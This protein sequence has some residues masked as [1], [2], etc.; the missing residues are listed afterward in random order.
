MGKGPVEPGPAAFASGTA[1]RSP[2]EVTE[3]LRNAGLEESEIV[4]FG[5][6]DAKRLGPASAGRVS[7]L[8]EHFSPDELKALGNFLFR[9]DIVINDKFVQ[10]LL[11][12]VERGHLVEK[13]SSLEVAA[14]YTSETATIVDVEGGLS[15]KISS[16]KRS[17]AAKVKAPSAPKVKEPWE[18]AEEQ[19]GPAL[20]KLYGK[21]WRY[22]ERVP[23][24]GVQPGETL[25]STIPEYYHP[26][27]NPPLHLKRNDYA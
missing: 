16:S 8:A 3:F 11:E 4:S 2:A 25:G 14:T 9:H 7:R 20:E 26:D 23:A 22:H 24:P 27:L 18:L 15:L 17:A 10:M 13:L 6:A 12:R 21:G 5:A 19:L 1:P